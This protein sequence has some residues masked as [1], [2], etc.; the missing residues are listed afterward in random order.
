MAIFVHPKSRSPTIVIPS[1]NSLILLKRKL[2]SPLT[3]NTLVLGKINLRSL[4]NIPLSMLQIASLDIINSRS[5]AMQSDMQS[6]ILSNPVHEKSIAL[7]TKSTGDYIK[8]YL[9]KSKKTCNC[10]ASRLNLITYCST[11]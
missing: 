6:D 9:L 4:T 2:R 3:V 10:T 1:G 7:T 11:G 8:T 5:K